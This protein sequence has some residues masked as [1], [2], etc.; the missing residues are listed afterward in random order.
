MIE[1]I[2]Y[3]LGKDT[4]MPVVDIPNGFTSHEDYLRHLVF[5]TFDEKF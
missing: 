1:D 3:G 2:D 4:I 5:E